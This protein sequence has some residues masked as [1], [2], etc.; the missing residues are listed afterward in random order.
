MGARGHPDR[1]GRGEALKGGDEG[2]SSRHDR[3]YRRL[4]GV[5]PKSEERGPKSEIGPKSEER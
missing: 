3:K 1:V 2:A 5:G 4:E